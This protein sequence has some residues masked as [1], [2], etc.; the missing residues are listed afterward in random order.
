MPISLC[1]SKIFVNFGIIL[2]SGCTQAKKE[3][4]IEQEEIKWI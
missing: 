4:L 1:R 3:N 2:A